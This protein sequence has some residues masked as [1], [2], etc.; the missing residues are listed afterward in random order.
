MA[1]NGNNREFKEPEESWTQYTERLEQYFTANEIKDAKKQCTILLI[2]CKCKTYGFISDLLQPK[3]LRD[4]DL[5]KIYEKL[6]NHFSPTA[7]FIAERFK[8]QSRNRPKGEK[9]AKF[10]AGLKSLSEHC[11]FGLTANI[12]WD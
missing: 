2:V 8:Y 9:V 3:K 6:E 4:K 12:L 7:S 10:V 1:T 11:Q 5:I